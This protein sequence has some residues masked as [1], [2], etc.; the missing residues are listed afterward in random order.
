[1]QGTLDTTSSMRSTRR[2]GA[3]RPTASTSISSTHGIRAL[4][5]TRRSARSTISCAAGKILYAGCSNFLAYQLAR[6]LGRS[7]TLGLARFD[8]AATRHNLLFRQIEREPAVV[9]EEGVGVIPYNPLAGGFLTGKHKPGAPTE[10]TR[11]TLGTA[12]DM[13]QE[14]YWNERAFATVE[15]IRPL[16]ARRGHDHGAVGGGMGARAPRSDGAHHRRQ[17]PRAAGRCR[18]RPVDTGRRPRRDLDRG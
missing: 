5:S 2:Y 16:A 3:C 14:R 11:F 13:Y 8:S 9:L 6:S 10:S 1:M 15:A 12:A 7:E 4:R 18:R 17:P